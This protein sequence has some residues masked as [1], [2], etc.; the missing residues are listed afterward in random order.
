MHETSLVRTLISQID[1]LVAS[2]GGGALRRVRVQIGPLSGVEPVL[3]H[4]AWEQLRAAAG[5][6][7][8][9]LEIEETPLVAHCRTCDA[10][11]EPAGFRFRC[12]ACGGTQT[13]AVSGDGVVL[14]SIVLDDVREGTTV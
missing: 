13:E 1:E 10:A 3:V 4:S 6:G 7:T 8:A 9:V 2:N 5:F 14:D 12:P 11:F